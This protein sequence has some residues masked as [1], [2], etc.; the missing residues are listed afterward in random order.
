M[1]YRHLIV[2]DAVC[3]HNSITK[4]ANEL[5]IAQPA[6]SSTISEIEK[7]YGISLFTRINQRIVLTEEG[8]NLWLKAKE[9]I[10]SFDEFEQMAYSVQ[11]KPSL[12]IGATFTIGKL[13]MP[14]LINNLKKEYPDANIH[15]IINQATLLEEKIQNGIIDFAFVERTPISKDMKAIPIGSDNL[16]VACGMEYN[17]NNH[18]TIQELSNHPVLL[19][20][21]GSASSE[22]LKSILELNHLR[23]NIFM[24]SSS[25]EVLIASAIENLG[26]I[27]LPEKLLKE[28]I[29]MKKLKVLNV[30]NISLSRI[31]NAI[32]HKNKKFSDTKNK[33]YDFCIEEIKKIILNK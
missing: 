14:K 30:E 1:T 25:N 28:F 10:S 20:E 4:A 21:G 33:I 12:T 23:A 3:R 5:F 2:F 22:L 16:L 31:Y 6:V 24:E 26:L 15:L 13:Y 11:S 9:L 7:K 8:K 27:A 32:T 19:R 17:I 29:D 18:I